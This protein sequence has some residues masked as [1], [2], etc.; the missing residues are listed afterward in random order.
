MHW[1]SS[2]TDCQGDCIIF[3]LATAKKG[4]FCDHILILVGVIDFGGGGIMFLYEVL[5]CAQA[6]AQ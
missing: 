4:D 1:T 2:N 5:K 6:L 3:G